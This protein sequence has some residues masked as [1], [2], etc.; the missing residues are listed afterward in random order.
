MGEPVAMD[1]AVDPVEF[2]WRAFP[3]VGDIDGDGRPDLLVGT[4]KGRV[5]PQSR[6]RRPARL[7]PAPVWFEEICF[8]GRIPVG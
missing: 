1:V 4:R 3:A 8:D 7:R 2:G 5:L 6:D